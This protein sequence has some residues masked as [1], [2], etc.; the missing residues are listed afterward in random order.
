MSKQTMISFLVQ[1]DQPNVKPFGMS[2]VS[3]PQNGNVLKIKNKHFQVGGVLFDFDAQ[4][5]TLVAKE[6]KL[7]IKEPKNIIHES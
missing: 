1:T 7:Q 4:R 3:L 2:A 5:I 6:M